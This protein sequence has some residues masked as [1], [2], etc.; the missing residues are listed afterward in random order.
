MILD[1]AGIVIASPEPRAKLDLTSQ[2]LTR[3]SSKLSHTWRSTRKFIIMVYWKSN[4]YSFYSLVCHT[5]ELLIFLILFLLTNL[6]LL[7][8]HLECVYILSFYICVPMSCV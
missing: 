3:L 6:F 2:D 4:I 5:Y 7:W 8:F 1:V